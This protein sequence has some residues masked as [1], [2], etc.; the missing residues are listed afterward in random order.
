MNGLVGYALAETKTLA[1]LGVTTYVLGSAIATM[2][3]RCGWRVRPPR[4]RATTS[5]LDLH[6]V[7]K[8]DIAFDVLRFFLRRRV[9]PCRIV[10]ERIGDD[11]VVVARG[12][13]PAADGVRRTGAK[14]L[15]ADCFRR[16]VVIALDDDRR[17]A[18]GEDGAVPRRFGHGR[19]SLIRNRCGIS[20]RQR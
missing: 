12:T 17:V 19:F 11:D 1:T 14:M 2:P 4:A 15:A 8:G 13:L 16:K 6:A 20:S 9:I 3:P 5:R 18:F 7:P 10:V